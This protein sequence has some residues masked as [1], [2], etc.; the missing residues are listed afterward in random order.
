MYTTHT[1]LQALSSLLR[2][3]TGLFSLGNVAQQCGPGTAREDCWQCD[4]Q[5]AEENV[6]ASSSICHPAD[7]TRG[8]EGPPRFWTVSPFQL[9][10]KKRFY[11]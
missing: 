2:L 6:N 7:S 10:S 4:E 11:I 1:G 3:H 5:R 9:V 8:P